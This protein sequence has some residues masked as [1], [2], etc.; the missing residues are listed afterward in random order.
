MPLKVNATLVKTAR[1]HSENMAKQEK[2]AHQLDGKSV[3]DRTEAA[4][5]DYRDQYGPYVVPAGTVF[6][7]GDDRD[8]SEDSRFF[9]VIPIDQTTGRPVCVYWSWDARAHRVR[10]TRLFRRVQ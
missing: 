8:D 1:A 3:G 4:G 6:V 10:W 7:L 5:Y 2:M 9:G